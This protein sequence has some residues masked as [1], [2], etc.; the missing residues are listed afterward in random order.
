MPLGAGLAFALKYKGITDKVAMTLYGDGGANQG[1][2]YEAVNMAKL[3]NL[4]LLF[5]CEN[6]RYAMGTP[7]SRHS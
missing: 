3:W 1:Q 2:L 4:P 6:N 7:I 5:F